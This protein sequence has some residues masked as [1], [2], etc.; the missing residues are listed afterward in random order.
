MSFGGNRD[1][2]SSRSRGRLLGRKVVGD[3][4]FASLADE[5]GV[6]VACF[7]QPAAFD[8]HVSAT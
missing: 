1:A 4:S 2:C 8:V 5:V 3:F 7:L 6:V